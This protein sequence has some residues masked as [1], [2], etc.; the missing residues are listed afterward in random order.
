V[1]PLGLVRL[2]RPG[3]CVEDGVGDAREVAAFE[4]GVVLHADSGQVGDLAAAQ[5]W[6]SPVA[7]VVV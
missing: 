3:K 4:L 1:R 6:H 5:S 7:V 2:Q